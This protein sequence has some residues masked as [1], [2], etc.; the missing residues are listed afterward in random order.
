MAELL[1]NMLTA[2]APTAR[3]FKSESMTA[4]VTILE[5]MHVEHGLQHL[6]GELERAWQLCHLHSLKRRLISMS[7]MRPGKKVG[8]N[9]LSQKFG[10]TTT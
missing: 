9:Q 4:D 6:P 3:L 7:T 1:L 8:P 10:V 2:A 5:H